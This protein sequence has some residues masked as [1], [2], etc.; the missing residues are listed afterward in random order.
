MGARFGRLRG[1]QAWVAVA[2]LMVATIGIAPAAGA[3][4]VSGLSEIAPVPGSPAQLPWLEQG[5]VPGSAPASVTMQRFTL[6]SLAGVQTNNSFGPA[7]V[8]ASDVA[9]PFDGGYYWVGPYLVVDGWVTNDT[10]AAVGPIAVD[11][12]VRTAAGVTVA[13]Q[14]FAAAVYNLP[15]SDVAVFRGMFELPAYSGSTMTV[16]VATVAKQ[17]SMYPSAVDLTV[18]DATYKVDP[19]GVRIHTCTLRND[20]SIAVKSPI[21][22][23]LEIDSNDKVLDVLFGFDP[24][25]VIQPGGTVQ[26]DA[27][28]VFPN[29]TP[30]QVGIYAQAIPVPQGSKEP[31]FRFFNRRSGAHFYTPD[32]AERDLVIAQ[33][34]G[35]FTYEGVAYY[36]NPA[37]NNK[38]LF[39]FFYKRGG[40]HFYTADSAEAAM[41][42]SRWPHIFNYEGTT[43]PVCAQQVADSTTVYRFINRKTSSHFYT[44]SAEERDIVQARF[45]S[46]FIYEGVAFWVAE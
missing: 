25:A 31:V 30:A 2:V 34:P 14:R 4:T 3:T 22:G 10:A 32:V 44:A 35:I 1:I 39:R 42:V 40:S 13:T 36:T 38:P 15:A 26:V 37:T 8:S 28:G 5:A 45:S 27:Y 29:V 21:V 7:E 17:P 18:V 6:D 46:T 9:L 19:D 43:Y 24:D 16:L 11:I 23:G 12:E 41:I 33:W 20:S